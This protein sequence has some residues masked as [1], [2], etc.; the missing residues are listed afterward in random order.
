MARLLSVNVG[1]PRDIVWRGRTVRTSIWKAPVRGARMVRRLNVDGDAQ[2]D[3]AGHGGEHRAVFVYQTG[4][5]EYWA[6]HFSRGDFLSG[7]FGENF[8]VDDMSDD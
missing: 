2:G 6:T 1:Q 3:T 8:T 7:Q 4:S 5:Y